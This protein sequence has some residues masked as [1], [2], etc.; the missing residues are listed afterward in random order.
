[1]LNYHAD[2]NDTGGDV[3]E[4]CHLHLSPSVNSVEQITESSKDRNK[5]EK[6]VQSGNNHNA[7]SCN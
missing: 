1:M 6:L 5:Q 3:L 7:L 2:D 4:W